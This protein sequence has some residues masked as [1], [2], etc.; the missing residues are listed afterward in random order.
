MLTFAISTTL[1]VVLVIGALRF[2]AH[3]RSQL[4]QAHS[5]HE[6]DTLPDFDVEDTLP[7]LK[8]DFLD[9]ILHGNKT[10]D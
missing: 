9:S 2:L 5:L 4:R 10:G 3:R 8:P 6:R 1:F 7:S